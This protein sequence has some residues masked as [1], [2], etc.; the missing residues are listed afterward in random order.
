M[1]KTGSVIPANS[2]AGPWSGLGFGDTLGRNAL[3]LRRAGEEAT[4]R[5]MDGG[6]AS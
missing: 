4:C 3:G 2:L 5:T 6:L 1:V